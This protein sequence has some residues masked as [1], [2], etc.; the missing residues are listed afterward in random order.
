[1]AFKKKMEHFNGEKYI[2]L[3]A[4]SQRIQSQFVVETSFDTSILL[5]W[6][7]DLFADI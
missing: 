4:K 3:I 6:E 5:G 2:L 1:M 7:L